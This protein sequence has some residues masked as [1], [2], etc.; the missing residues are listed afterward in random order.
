MSRMRNDLE[1]VDIVKEL[2]SWPFA[3][4]VALVFAAILLMQLL[5]NTISGLY[6]QNAYEAIV[7]PYTLYIVLNLYWWGN[8]LELNKTKLFCMGV[9]FALLFLPCLYLLA[10]GQLDR[11]SLIFSEYDAS[12]SHLPYANVLPY[13]SIAALVI[14]YKNFLSRENRV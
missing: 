1:S 3:L 6:F 4:F 8:G 9:S 2:S 10:S 5:W 13:I 7:L 14:P 12:L 11:H